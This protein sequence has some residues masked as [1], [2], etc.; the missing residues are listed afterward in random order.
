MPN[1]VI[2]MFE[3]DAKPAE[4]VDLERRDEVRN[5]AKHLWN[6]KVHYNSTHVYAPSFPDV[7]EVYRKAGR[8][9]LERPGK[10]TVKEVPD[11]QEDTKSEPHWSDLNSPEMRALAENYTDEPV[12]NKKQAQEILTQVESE[13]LL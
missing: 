1:K 9:V 11:V 7:E 5:I 10:Q 4:L 3:Q 13:G 2:M 8:V 12:K 6:G